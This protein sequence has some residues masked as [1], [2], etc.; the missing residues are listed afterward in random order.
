MPSFQEKEK[1]VKKWFSFSELILMEMEL[2]LNLE[3]L[4]TKVLEQFFSIRPKIKFCLSNTSQAI[5]TKSRIDVNQC[6]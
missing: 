3:S 6:E 1:Q 4:E 2:K 5:K